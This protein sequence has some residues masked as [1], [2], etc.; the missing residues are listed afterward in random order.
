MLDEESTFQFSAHEEDARPARVRRRL[1]LVPTSL[2][3]VGLVAL[4]W[5]VSIV[6]VPRFILPF[7]SGQ[8]NPIPQGTLSPGENLFY[9]RSSLP[10][11]RFLLDGQPLSKLPDPAHDPPLVLSPGTHVLIWQA[12]PFLS[13]SCRLTIVPGQLSIGEA[14]DTHTLVTVPTG[15]YRG[16]QANLLAFTPSS[17]LLPPEQRKALFAV[18]AH[19]LAGF[20]ASDLLR[21]GE[22]FISVSAPNQIAIAQEPLRVTLRL[23][24]DTDLQ[25]RF[26]CLAPLFVL[27]SGE[28]PASSCDLGG[29][30]CHTLCTLIPELASPLIPQLSGFPAGTWNVLA[31]VRTS[32][33]YSTL[34]GQIVA[35]QQPDRAAL[36]GDEYTLYLH[37]LW[38]QEQG[39]QVTLDSFETPPICAVARAAVAQLSFET[40]PP[41]IESGQL[42]HALPFEHTSCLL[43]YR[44]LPVTPSSSPL[45]VLLLYRSGLIQAANQAAHQLW[46]TL[47][48]FSIS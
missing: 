8:P 40:R 6:I 24:L 10:G 19:L 41:Y 17:Q 7:S 39:W 25:S 38:Q 22:P 48:Q 21:P 9:L 15:S 32:W 12:P 20:Q 4:L 1:P 29:Q 46:P 33:D 3:I 16:L 14:C 2:I 31:T 11:S 45:D 23:Q 18:I 35:R 30:N 13:Q 47:P 42:L 5:L 26:I 37:V 34:S 44:F 27:A 28:Q 36:E 43:N